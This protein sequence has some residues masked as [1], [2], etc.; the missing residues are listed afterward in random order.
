MACVK[1]IARTVPRK[2]VC[3]LAVTQEGGFS[4]AERFKTS[5]KPRRCKSRVEVCRSTSGQRRGILPHTL[6]VAVGHVLGWRSRGTRRWRHPRGM[7][8][9]PGDG[10]PG[11][12]PRLF[13]APCGRVMC[14]CSPER[15]ARL[16]VGAAGIPQHCPRA[17]LG[18]GLVRQTRKTLF[19]VRGS[20][21]RDRV[22]HKLQAWSQ[23]EASL[24][25]A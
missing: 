4:Q 8:Q 24:L 9:C 5:A 2:W 13:L 10:A 6:G 17:D 11:R 19:V 7:W 25:H 15:G 12:A 3:W 14:K 1:R 22:R 21:I 16:S 18:V 20:V 23:Q